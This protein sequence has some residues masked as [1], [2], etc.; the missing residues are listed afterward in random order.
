[1][2]AKITAQAI[3]LMAL[4][5]AAGLCS[6]DGGREV[7]L[8]ANV[9]LAKGEPSNDI[10]GFGIISRHRLNDE[11]WLGFDLNVSNK[12][13]FERP[14]KSVGLRQGEGE[15]IDAVGSSVMLSVLAERRH[16][17]AGSNKTWFW[18]AGLGI[19]S[20]DIEDVSG[21][22]ADG[23]TFDIKTDADIETVLLGGIGLLHRF[24][25]SGRWSARY[26]LAVE[27][28]FADWK[29]EDRV[30]GNTGKI[31][32]YHTIGPRFGLNYMFQ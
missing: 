16:A 4:T 3:C 22:T 25:D 26:E 19:N 32:S 1:M 30:S 15:T 21:P 17:S 7:G 27:Y 14:W 13:D 5:G 28:R 31:D 8:R 24:S 10:P 12:F 11:W 29:V 18:N 23:G 20:L 2:N 6:A 9:V